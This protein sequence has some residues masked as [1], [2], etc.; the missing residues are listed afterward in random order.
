MSTSHHK[1]TLLALALLSST[2]F[3][4]ADMPRNHASR[5]RSAQASDAFAQSANRAADGGRE[6]WQGK[7][8]ADLVIDHQRWMLSVPIGVSAANPQETGANCG[9]NQQGPVWNLVGPGGLSNFTVNCTVPAGKAIFMPALGY[10]YEFP[11]PEPYPQL[12]AGQSLEAFLR[13]MTAEAIDGITFASITLDNRPVRLRRAATGIFPF[14]A[15]KDWATYDVCITG[16]PQ[17]AQVDGLWALIDPPSVG[18]HVVSLKLT[19]PWFGTVEGTWNLNVT[20]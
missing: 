14:T 16:A 15:A 13:P 9:I 17:V 2:Q 8:I 11:C 5:A 1:A 7:S 3:A 12:P 10:F 18:K 6:F 4:L 20:R 19:H